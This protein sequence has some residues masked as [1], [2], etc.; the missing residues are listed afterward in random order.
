MPPKA[1]VFKKESQAIRAADQK[2]LMGNSNPGKS[3]NPSTMRKSS[4]VDGKPIL[5]KKAEIH[6][7]QLFAK[8]IKDGFNLARLIAT[9]AAR[10]F[11]PDAKGPS[12]T[13]FVVMPDS[14]GIKG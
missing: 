14:I 8:A 13:R 10:Y 4:L 2:N 12:E 6:F 7:Q 11:G 5:M 3:F 1:T 9:L